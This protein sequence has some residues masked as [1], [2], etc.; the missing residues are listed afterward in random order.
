MTDATDVNRQRLVG[1]LLDRLAIEDVLRRYCRAIDRC[2]G[3][4]LRTCYHADAYDDHGIFKGS[5][6]DF[7]EFTMSALLS[8]HESHGQLT[9]H[10]LGNVSIDIAGV[11][12][13][14]ETYFNAAHVEDRDDH[15]RVFEFH[16]RY[17]DRLERRLGE[18]R[19]VHRRVVH[20][21]SEIRENRRGLGP[22]RHAY[23]QGAIAPHDPSYAGWPLDPALD[24]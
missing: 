10:V 8:R 24:R 11:H 9:T 18:W 17:L 12:A 20:D 19:L 7:V 1:H 5:R 3:E 6:D 2:D 16:G 21:W 23:S 13:S 22:G 4:L 15:F 14:A